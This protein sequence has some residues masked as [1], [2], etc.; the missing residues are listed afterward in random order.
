[1][2]NRT[3][4]DSTVLSDI[5]TSVQVAATYANGDFVVSE[6]EVEARFPHQHYGWCR[7][8]VTGA[9][10]DQADMLDVETGDATP[11]TANNWVQSWHVLKRSGLPVVYCN[12]GNEQAVV[13]AC[14]AGGSE[15]G[16][17]YGLCVATLDGTQVTGPGVVACQHTSYEPAHWDESVVYDDTLWLPVAPVPV[18]APAPKPPAVSKAQALAALSTLSGFVTEAA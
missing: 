9:L 5:P 6:A 15:L 8:D 16:T 7:I 12:R 4:G 17:H 2:T 1:L 10:A 18:P 11:E 14:K 13:D 3:M